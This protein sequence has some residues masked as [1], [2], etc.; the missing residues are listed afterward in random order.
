MIAS[1]AVRRRNGSFRPNAY[2][3]EVAPLVPVIPV[4]FSKHCRASTFFSAVTT[5]GTPPDVTLELRIE[6]FFPMNTET[7]QNV[8][9]LMSSCEP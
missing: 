6:C 7:E 4:S 1:A 5:L 9:A 3:L 8:H 2:G